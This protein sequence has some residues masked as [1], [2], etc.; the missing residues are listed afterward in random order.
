MAS[1]RD[2]N[3]LQRWAQSTDSESLTDK[4][5]ILTINLIVIY[6]VSEN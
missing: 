4:A 3:R 1:E 6:V 5:Y 2:P